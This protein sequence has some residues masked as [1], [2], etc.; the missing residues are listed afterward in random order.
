MSAANDQASAWH[1][2]SVG[3]NRSGMITDDTLQV[4]RLSRDDP[5]WMRAVH[6]AL[7]LEA[8]PHG[9]VAPQ[10]QAL[11]DAES[12]GN[13]D[14]MRLDVVVAAYL[15]GQMC[16]AAL[17]GETPGHSAL[18]F[19]PQARRSPETHTQALT[20]TLASLVT[21][22]RETDLKL[23]QAL[24][25]PEAEGLALAMRGSGFRF[26]TRLLYLQSDVTAAEPGSAPDSDIRWLAYG[27]A[28]RQI[29]CEALDASYA[30]TSDC[31]ELVGLRS[32]EDALAGHR[33]SGSF[34][35]RL[36]WVALRDSTPLGILLLARIDAASALE[37]VYIGVA[38]PVRGQG[39]ADVLMHRAMA[40]ARRESATSLTLA[41]DRDNA[42]ARALY[43]KWGF[44]ER[45]A[46][47][48]WIATPHFDG[49]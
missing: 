17:A 11:L 26:L 13:R 34:D 7:D 41:V 21:I 19:A 10:V 24:V 12:G 4:R 49:G 30:Q 33:A 40:A 44:R 9:G 47:D 48:A 39:L 37:L 18:V 38:Q 20:R 25:A 46:R 23:L 16:C 8:E 6:I 43:A 14:A 32:T 28:H 45:F 2:S 36:W 3:Y 5:D 22:S 42:P 15:N 31:K 1:P 35:S 27:P 29:F